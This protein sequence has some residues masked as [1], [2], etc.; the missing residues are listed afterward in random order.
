MNGVTEFYELFFPVSVSEAFHVTDYGPAGYALFVAVY[1][2]LEVTLKIQ[3]LF[4]S[5]FGKTGN[6]LMTLINN[7]ATDHFMPYQVMFA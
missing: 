7:D 5:R 6:C 2:G 3:N 4:Y 1:A